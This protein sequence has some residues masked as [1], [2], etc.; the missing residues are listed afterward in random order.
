MVRPV[1]N[2]GRAGGKQQMHNEVPGSLNDSS[3]LWNKKHQQQT[4][5]QERKPVT[6][7]GKTTPNEPRTGQQ[8][9]GTTPHEHSCSPRQIPQRASTG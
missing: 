6:K 9:I 3:R 2:A 7:P 1:N 8:E 5:Y 4:T